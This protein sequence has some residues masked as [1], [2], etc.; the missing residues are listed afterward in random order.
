MSFYQNTCKPEGFAGKFMV[1]MMNLGHTPMAKWGLQHIIIK[2][3]YHCLDIGCGGGQNIKRLLKKCRYGKVTGL[4]YSEVSVE[5]SIKVNQVEIDQNRCEVLQGDVM[6]LPFDQNSFDVITAFE[7][8]YFW[9]DLEIAFQQIYNTLKENGTFLICN[10]FNGK[11]PKEQKWKDKI[12]GL[13]IYTIEQLTTYLKNAGFKNI[14]SDQN[15]TG[16][17]SIIANK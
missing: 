9:P 5:K 1:S 11:N 12:D 6:N 4:D 3:D 17:I 13:N 16:W 8:L 15:S 14:Q 10:E 2:E 7:T